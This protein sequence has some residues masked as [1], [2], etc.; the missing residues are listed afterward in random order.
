[1]YD[2]TSCLGLGFGHLCFISL[3]GPLDI[4][5]Y[6]VN[7]YTLC[8]YMIHGY[9]LY[10]YTLSVCI[11]C[12][13]ACACVRACVCVCVSIYIWYIDMRKMDIPGNTSNMG[14]CKKRERKV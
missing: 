2:L 8:G 13:C 5:V 11:L 9:I 3:S 14:V 12:V 7:R 4:Y 6:T 10:V 1:M